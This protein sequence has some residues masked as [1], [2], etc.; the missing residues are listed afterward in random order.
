MTQ[1]KVLRWKVERLGGKDARVKWYMATASNAEQLTELLGSA[2]DK[3][4][5][6]RVAE[7]KVIVGWEIIVNT[8]T[9][10][11]VG[12]KGVGG[13]V[14][15]KVWKDEQKEKLISGLETGF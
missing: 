1:K 3:S 5:D 9:K 4:A 15:V 14:W 2:E 7:D 13:G 6:V 10:R 12:R 11:L 8:T